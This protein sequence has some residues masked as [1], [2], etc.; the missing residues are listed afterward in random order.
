MKSYGND[1]GKERELKALRIGTPLMLY[2]F[3]SRFMSA[4]VEVACTFSACH[5]RVS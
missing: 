4:L 5:M 2:F 3:E 1:P